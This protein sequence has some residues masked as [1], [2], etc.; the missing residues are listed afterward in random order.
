MKAIKNLWNNHFNAI[1]VTGCSLA[2][3]ILL[4]FLEIST[5]TLLHIGFWAGFIVFLIV[6]LSLTNNDVDRSRTKKQKFFWIC[7]GVVTTLFLLFS[8]S[9]LEIMADSWIAKLRWSLFVGDLLLYALIT[10]EISESKENTARR[11]AGLREWRYIINN[12]AF[13]AA[14]FA[15]VLNFFNLENRT[16]N[17]YL[18]ISFIVMG[19][20]YVITMLP[21][22]RFFH[23]SLGGLLVILV[24]FILIAVFAASNN[25]MGD[26]I[27]HF[28][29][30]L[31]LKIVSIINAG[32]LVMGL[33]LVPTRRKDRRG[34][35]YCG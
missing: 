3:L 8:L 19:I 32:L 34:M 5:K 17:D 13:T 7:S 14:L 26:I 10:F 6:G 9:F 2:L 1:L 16:I 33:I 21:N 20:G 18:I 12:T 25:P 28:G 35:E 27:N 24:A 15:L 30:P 31:T 23:A 29:D 22:K 11:Q 4:Y